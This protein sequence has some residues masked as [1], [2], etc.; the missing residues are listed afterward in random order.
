MQLAKAKLST[1]PYNAKQPHAEFS[2]IDEKFIPPG[3]WVDVA[4][5]EGGPPED[6]DLVLACPGPMP[7]S[8]NAP[9]MSNGPQGPIRMLGDTTNILRIK[10]PLP[11]QVVPARSEVHQHGRSEVQE[12][13]RRDGV[14]AVNEPSAATHIIQGN[15]FT[16]H[17]LSP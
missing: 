11:S 6:V 3:T 10:I 9:P 17:V 12:S 4:D 8:V 14:D 13:Q 2:F 1:T 7:T 16:L 5:Y 15:G